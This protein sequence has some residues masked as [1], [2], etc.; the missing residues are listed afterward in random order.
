MG[1]MKVLQGLSYT[2]YRLY[3][4]H[5]AEIST[6]Q[7]M[8]KMDTKTGKIIHVNYKNKL[9]IFCIVQVRHKVEIS[10]VYYDT[11]YVLYRTSFLQ[12]F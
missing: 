6:L 4:N 11:I 12:I 9:C 2:V 7:T 5:T 10:T 1:S 8:Y 3:H